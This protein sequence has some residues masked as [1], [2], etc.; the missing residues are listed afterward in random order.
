[1]ARLR[2]KAALAG[3]AALLGLSHARA[4]SDTAA[5]SIASGG[6]I[7]TLT[8]TTF[9]SDVLESSGPAL[10]W[11]YAGADCPQCETLLP[12]V[13]GAA[14]KLSS[15]GVSVSAVDLS[16]ETKLR[17]D[18]SIPKGLPMMFK[19][20]HSESTPNPYG[21]LPVRAEQLISIFKDARD[22]Q[23]KVLTAIPDSVTS[24]DLGGGSAPSP[25]LKA[26]LAER[27]QEFAAVLFTEAGLLAG[28]IDVEGPLSVPALVLVDKTSGKGSVYDGSVDDA[29]AMLAF[30]R[31]GADFSES[32][33][34]TDADNGRD[35]SSGGAPMGNRMGGLLRLDPGLLA[36]LEDK[37][38]EALV[39]AFVDG[40]GDVEEAVP[41]WAE[42]TKALQGQVR[43][44]VFDCAA[45]PEGCSKGPGGS[46]KSTK[47]P[48][49]RVYPH[50]K[51]VDGDKRG[52]PS[53]FPAS[54]VKEAVAEAE[55]SLPE[56]VTAIPAG[57]D[58]QR[59][60]EAVQAF[61]G[62]N[63]FSD[64]APMCLLVMSRREEPN[65][66]VKTVS[67]AFQEAKVKTLFI[68]K[69]SEELLAGV[70]VFKLPAMLLMFPE[71][72][73]MQAE[74]DP[75]RPRPRDGE[76]AMVTAHY[77]PAH[78]GSVTHQHFGGEGEAGSSG[79]PEGN[80]DGG[81][82]GG[83]AARFLG[84]PEVNQEVWSSVTGGDGGQQ[85]P[86]TVGVFFL[87]RFAEGFA[88]ALKAAESAAELAAARLGRGGPAGGIGFIWAD[89]PCQDGFAKALG[90]SDASEVPALVVFSPKHQ[91]SAKFVGA[92]ESESLGTFL[93]RALG[94]RTP[95][96]PIGGDDAPRL[97]EST[98]CSQRPVPAWLSGGDGGGEGGGDAIED[99]DMGDFMAEI[100]ADEA[101]AKRELEEE[102]ARGL[103]E[104]K[105]AEAAE[106][107]APPKRTKKT[108][109]KKKKKKSKSGSRSEL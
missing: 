85:S 31:D 56:L 62:A 17:R 18:L 72:E 7:A 81:G 2:H 57:V 83:P 41:G 35:G 71:Q 43:A 32:A 24:L 47:A 96:F 86:L 42:A 76:K 84:V 93:G 91:K 37:G 61:I 20:Y 46:S 30:I 25:G 94:G 65:L 82:V 54:E 10:V 63:I 78:W 70:G 4:E 38:T 69:P 33:P 105:E 11:L 13:E 28:V 66:V 22:L 103:E 80:T 16:E 79:S 59:V 102:V 44:A 21:G 87:D 95:L 34:D 50:G 64:G 29:K 99:D 104:Q 101:K 97:D 39:V 73:A 52:F 27:E 90:V 68:S 108:V 14:G 107:A 40:G 100:L 6:R 75:N 74:M 1:M 109:K 51:G 77:N 19:V 23:K 3:A 88:A 92:W 5:F 89:A 12:F 45:H 48:H 98:D 49:I 26:A 67:A 8:R 58:D 106:A 60:Q 55:A 36:T 15:W 53:L 9:I